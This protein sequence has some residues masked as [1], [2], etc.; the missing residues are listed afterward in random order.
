VRIEDTYGYQRDKAIT[1]L[2]VSRHLTETAIARA[3]PL[4]RP[5][6]RL[7]LLPWTWRRDALYRRLVRQRDGPP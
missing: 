3:H 4:A 5:F 1:E 6:A 7:L 2:E